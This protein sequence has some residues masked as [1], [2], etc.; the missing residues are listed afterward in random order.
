MTVFV[1]SQIEFSDSLNIEQYCIGTVK[2]MKIKRR[3][4][5]LTEYNEKYKIKES[6]IDIRLQQYFKDHEYDL[7]KAVRK[8]N[9]KLDALYQARHWKTIHIIFYEYPMK[10]D[11]PRHTRFGKTYSPNAAENHKYFEKAFRSIEKVIG[12]IK[13]IHTPASIHIEAYL[14]MPEQIKPEEVILYE[15]KVLHPETTPDYDNIAKCYTDMLK[16]VIITDDDIFYAGSCQ[17]FY[18]VLPRVEMYIRYLSEHESDYVIR[19]LKSRKSFKEL[20]KAGLVE[21]ST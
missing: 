16:N 6:D 11:R 1:I 2:S 14:E 12:K 5:L 21:I 4:Q 20:Q 15:Y 13:L 19:K 18:S 10:T 9:Q 8:A 17:K 7:D 3:K